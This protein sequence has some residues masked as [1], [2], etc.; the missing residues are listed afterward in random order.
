MIP[1]AIN[2]V[3]RADIDQLVARAV[4]EDNQLDFKEALVGSTRDERKEFVA[5]VCAFANASGGDLVFGIR[6]N[7]AG[8]AREAVP[9]HINV[10]E[11]SLRLENVIADSIEPKLYGVRTRAVPYEQGHVLVVRVPRSVRGIHRSKLDQHFWV[12]ES[13][14]K[15]ALDLPAVVNRIEGQLG[16]REKL[17]SFLAERYASILT[18]RLPVP[19]R[20]GP[21]MVVH[22]IPDAGFIE[23]AVD[24]GPVSDAGL[25]PYP[26]RSNGA[27]FRMTFDGPMHHSP[28]VDGKIRA[29][30]LV[31]HSGIVEGCWKAADADPGEVRIGAETLELHLLRYL[32]EALPRIIETLSIDMPV[33][34][35][36]A[37]IGAE[38]AI[39]QTENVHIRIDFDEQRLSPVDRQCL[40]LPDVYLEQ[41]P[42]D[43]PKSFQ[44]S[45]DRLWQ[46][47]GYKRSYQYQLRE[48]G[49]T[50]IGQL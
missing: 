21:R 10:D 24:V 18:G 8:A 25:F 47:A 29:Y 3:E 35:R 23:E 37:L 16:R 34:V 26:A 50:W 39:L 48:G 2:A 6:E 15:R 27:D 12:R 7:G 32:N 38:G 14:S 4:E 33:T 1:K 43:L 11:E 36:S 17:E 19:L 42:I 30:S 31:H 46:A 49:L 22:L 40:V 13:R 45:F 44:S 41:W 9:L 20:D 28:I 5:D